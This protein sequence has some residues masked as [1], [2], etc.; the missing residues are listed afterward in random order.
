MTFNSYAFIF[1]FFP[2]CLI[3]LYAVGRRGNGRAAGLWLSLMSLLF[4]GFNSPRSLPVLAGSL[5][6]GW[7]FL[8]VIRKKPAHAKACAALAIVFHILVL[9]CFK[10]FNFFASM[11]AFLSGRTY[12]PLDI[13]H[14]LGI[15]FI[16]FQQISLVVDTVRGDAGEYSFRDYFLYILF[17]PKVLAGPITGFP[18]MKQQF[19]A[20]SGLRCDSGR[21]AQGG[22]LFLLGLG[23]KCILSGSLAAAADFAFAHAAS[24]SF[25]EAFVGMTAYMMELYFDFS[26]YCD[27]GRGICRMM[28]MELPVNFDSPL[29]SLNIVDFWKRW[30]ITLTRFLTRYLYIP[31]GGNRKGRR[32]MIAGMFL[33][34]LISGLWH[35]ADWTFLFWGALNGLLYIPVRLL[36]KKRGSTA[37][38]PGRFRKALY[39][40]LTFILVSWIFVPFRADSMAQY[41]VYNGRLFTGLLQ[42]QRF[43]FGAEF[44]KTFRINE[45]WYLMK[46]LH[47][48][49]RPEA[50]VLCMCIV[51]GIALFFALVSPNAAAC[52]EKYFAREKRPAVL[53]ALVLAVLFVWCVLSFGKVQTYI[54]LQF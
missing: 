2:V 54:Y 45:I 12:V 1:I 51:M 43:H 52:T 29:Q 35:G 7:L 3:V 19:D 14:P 13:L 31:M 26:G 44:L 10:Y 17:F 46:G 25:G 24:L 20:L 15:S 34:F 23:K 9:G 48:A 18:E 5:A 32:R 42:P 33:V 53:T 40:I 11:A 47:V 22:M 30:H 49:G 16:T 28:G 27:M 38:S 50:P 21:F 37:V 6:A 41:M 8:T 36:Q 4:F 39:R